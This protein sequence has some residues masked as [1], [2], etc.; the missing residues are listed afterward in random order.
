MKKLVV[1]LNT[2]DDAIRYVAITHNPSLY[3]DILKGN[4]REKG[5]RARPQLAVAEYL[6]VK[7]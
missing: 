6:E 5:K 4:W 7:S 3:I 1:S 2:W